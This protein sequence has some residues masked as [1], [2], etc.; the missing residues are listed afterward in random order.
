MLRS[1]R[2]GPLLAQVGDEDPEVVR[3][4]RLLEVEVGRAMQDDR[5]ERRLVFGRGLHVLELHVR[6]LLDHAL[7]VGLRLLEGLA[8]DLL[9]LRRERLVQEE[10]VALEQ[11]GEAEEDKDTANDLGD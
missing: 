2:G 3:D 6:E 11:P 1:A 8:A 10:V 7:V 9:V 5:G 4:L